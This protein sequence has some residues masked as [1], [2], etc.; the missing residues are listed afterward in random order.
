MNN[1]EKRIGENFAS[2]RTEKKK[3][4]NSE[5]AI[6]NDI[7]EYMLATFQIDPEEDTNILDIL[8]MM[9]APDVEASYVQNWHLKSL[10]FSCTDLI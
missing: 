9:I 7:K 5:E 10:D 6:E 4:E 3:K 2:W 1:V 8:D